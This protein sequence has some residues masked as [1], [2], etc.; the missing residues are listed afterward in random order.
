METEVGNVPGKQARRVKGSRLDQQSAWQQS[1]TEG[2]SVKNCPKDGSI[3][4][5]EDED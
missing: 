2:G 1:K 4:M 5:Q 3:S